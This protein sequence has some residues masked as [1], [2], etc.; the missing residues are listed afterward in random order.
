MLGQSFNANK[1]SSSLLN[2]NLRRA[3]GQNYDCSQL[4]LRHE[5]KADAIINIALVHNHCS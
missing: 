2:T 3:H 4:K 1:V 5:E